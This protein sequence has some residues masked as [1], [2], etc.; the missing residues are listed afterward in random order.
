MINKIASGSFQGSN[1]KRHAF[2]GI[3]VA[4]RNSAGS[5]CDIKAAS[6]E[7]ERGV[8]QDIIALAKKRKIKYKYSYEDAFSP[9]D[10]IY[11]FAF[12]WPSAK[13]I[14][15]VK[16][17]FGKVAIKY[18]SNS[19]FTYVLE[20]NSRDIKNSFFYQTLYRILNKASG[21]ELF[22]PESEPRKPANVAKFPKK[23]S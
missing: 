15:V 18:V 21:D 13:E 16:S 11:K 12:R 7:K 2:K 19:R 5:L 17:A 20:P 8:L 6:S 14:D 1:C 4:Q 10:I 23:K 22:G 3:T 9:G